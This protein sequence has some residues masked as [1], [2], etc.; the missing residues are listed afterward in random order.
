MN[1]NY[2]LFETLPLPQ[3]LG[4]VDKKKCTIKMHFFQ[5]S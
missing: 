3:F 1:L 5:M 2:T 4:S